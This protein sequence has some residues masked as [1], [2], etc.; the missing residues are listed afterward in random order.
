LKLESTIT[1]KGGF[2]Y[3]APLLD[4]VLLLLVF[5][6]IGSSSVSKSGVQ[7]D[8]PSSNSAFEEAR[9]IHIITVK[10]GT[11]HKVFFN[12][13]RVDLTQLNVKLE[14]GK[15]T[16]SQVTVLADRDAAYGAVME[17]ALRA[18]KFGYKVSFGTQPN[19]E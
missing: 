15:A 11:P 18:L 5:F 9:S 3:T 13:S 14:E 17:V 1:E 6:I 10:D 12:E 19:K 2:L 8:L 4:A 7:V 16:S